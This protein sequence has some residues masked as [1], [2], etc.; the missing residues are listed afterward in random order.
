MTLLIY[1]IITEFDK[2]IKLFLRGEG[3]I[4]MLT[5]H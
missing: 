5:R 4:F 1:K 3:L 2:E